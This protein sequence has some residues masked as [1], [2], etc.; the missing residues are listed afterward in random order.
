MGPSTEG[1]LTGL[2]TLILL[3]IRKKDVSFLQYF[4][5]V[6][7]CVLSLFYEKRM[8][9]VSLSLKEFLDKGSSK[10]CFEFFIHMVIRKG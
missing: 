1:S 3:S 6:I 9:F 10:Y 8:R 5:T 4:S 7:K 2:Q